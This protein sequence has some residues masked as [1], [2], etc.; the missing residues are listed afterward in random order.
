VRVLVQVAV[1]EH[2]G[3]VRRHPVRQRPAGTAGGDEAVGEHGGTAAVECH[4][5]GLGRRG[6]PGN[7]VFDLGECAVEVEEHGLDRAPLR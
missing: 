7:R 1:G 2:L 4:P 3:Q 5:A 6:H